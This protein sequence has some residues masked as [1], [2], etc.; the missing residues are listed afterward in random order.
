MAAQDAELLLK[1][2][3]DLSHFRGQLNRLG[4]D[5]AGQA[6]NLS[7][8]FNRSSVSS[9]LNLLQRQLG[10]KKF[11]VEV[12]TNLEAEIKNADRLVR[13]LQRVQSASSGAKGGL[14]LGVAGLGVKKG[15]GNPSVNEIRALFNAAI[16]G[17]LLDERTL[18]KT[19][20][21][22][23]V[24]LGQIGRDSI[25]G[26]LNGLSSGDSR[27]RAAAESLGD[28]LIAALK[29]ALGI[30]SPSKETGKLGKFAAEGFEKGFVSGMV[31]AERTMA[32]AIRS[33]VIGS[34]R[35]GLSN[36]P[37]LGG[38]LV[39]FERQ[40]AASVQLAV[41]RAMREGLS[42]SVGP[43][44]KGTLLGGT[45]G[46]ATGAAIGGAKALGGGIAAGVAKLTA[47]G[48]MGTAAN[49]ARY[50]I[51][52]SAYQEFVGK[53]YQEII[54]S[55][56]SSGS[57]GAI[58]GAL[59]VGGVAGGLGFARGATGSLAIQAITA[60]RNR[61]LAALLAVS[62][63]EMNNV[64]KVMVRDVTGALFTGIIRQLK[65]ASQGLPAINWPAIAPTKAAGIGPSSSGRFLPGGPEAAMLPGTAFGA[66]RRLVGDILSPSLKEALRG[67]ANA[68]VDTVRAELNAAIRQVNVRDLG[69]KV[70]AALA[71]SRIAGLLP[72]GVGR[73]PSTYATGRI[74]GETQAELFARR[75]REARMRSGL[76]GM[77]V[78]GGGAGR[79]PSPYS[80][81]YR[82]A[83]PLSAIVPYA[84][85]GAMV[86]TGGGGGGAGG[87][88][89]RPPGGGG[90]M[91]GGGG[92][93]GRALSNL[94][95]PGQGLIREL[96][97]EFG[98]AAKQVLLFGTAYKAL[99]FIQTFP[100][101]VGQAVGQL[102]SF[103]NTLKEISPSA[104][105]VAA[106]NKFILD[107]VDKYNVPLQSARDGFTKLYASM[108]P[109]GF[110]GNEIRDLFLGISQAAATFGM[111]AEKV[112]RV[113]YAFAQMA[114]KGQVMSEEL[115]GQ[116]GD[117][118]PGAMAIFA[119]A[120][121]F[122]GA[123]AITK[124][125][126][127]LE[128]GAYKG[129][130]MKVLLTNVGIVMRKEFGP[131]AEGAA[132]TFQGV[133]N[134]M[135]NSMKLLYEAFE[136]VAV[137]F[138]NS[139][140]MP[141][142]NGIK[143]ITDG[144]N[145]FFQ[146]VSAKTAGGQ[147][148]AAQ[149]ESLRPAFEG[150]LNNVKQLL[151]SLQLF[152]NA[153]L[154]VSKLFI[155]IAGNPVTGFLLKVYAN[156]LLLN[157]A[158]TLLGGRVLLGLIASINTAIAR[159]IA[160]NVSVA[161]LQRTSA[162]TSSALAGTQLQLALLT[163]NA[164][165]ATGPV[166]LLA[167]TLSRLAA[168]GAIVVT[169]SLIV[170]GLSE[171]IRAN[172]EIARLRGQRLAGGQAAIYGGSVPAQ[173]KETARKTL[174]SINKER[175][176][177]VPL[178]TRVLG[179]L[180]GLVGAP[181][182]AGQI[183]RSGVLAERELAA[184]AKLGLPTR[185]TVATGTEQVLQSMP[186]GAG[187]GAGKGG[188]K[189]AD[190]AKRLAEEIAKQAAAASNVLFTEQQRLS[191]LRAT[192]PIAKTFAEFASQELTIQREL[193][194]ALKEA[195]S[196]K[197]KQDIIETA[198]L[199]SMQ[200]S[201]T[202]EQEMQRV[203]EDALKPLQEL[204]TNQ[205]EQLRYET[206]VKDLM[207]QGMLPE[208]AKQVAE[209]RKLVRAQL[210]TLDLSIAQ[211]EAAIQER[212][213]RE[214]ITEAVQKQ[215]EALEDLRAARGQILG[216]G[217]QGEAGVPTETAKGPMDFIKEAAG[218]AREELDKLTNWG[219]QAVEGAKA[220]G[221]AF[222]Q[223]FK[224]I[225]S[226]SM[227]AQEALA[228]MMQSIADHFLDMAAQIIAQQ[229]TMMI[230][231]LILKAL[232]VMSGAAASVSATGPNPGGIPSTGNITAPSVN[233]FDLGS[234]ANV[235]AN[236]AVWKGGFQAF[237]NGGMVTGPTLGLIGEGKY[238]E[239]IVP[240]PN[241]R[242]IPVQLQGDSIREKMGDNYASSP[243]SPMLSMTFETTSINGVE[244]VS[245]DQLEAAM[246]ETR[247]LAAR[248]GAQKGAN[249]AIDKLQQSPNVRRRVGMR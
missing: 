20:E 19:R 197:E 127:A 198:R 13:A 97:Q 46:A 217:A 149:L 90:G 230:Y 84:P 21:Q 161:A 235:A 95:L 9:E 179:S 162:V 180:A 213:A 6:L 109:A 82:G 212:I 71:P 156:V 150:I 63:G 233:G 78:M 216:L 237:A 119:E 194:Q 4:S 157:T 141:L 166:A 168:I 49:L 185:A 32:N 202:L 11:R 240:L 232:G 189:A 10:N 174:A 190:E 47:G 177:G 25:E 81:A 59:A 77:D 186:A 51:D 209:V 167:S 199:K 76:R 24:A 34:I 80:Y 196:E 29:N 60:I 22:M 135:Q 175:K 65:S 193:N 113:N 83:R 128:D 68:F 226:G 139:V 248:E 245:R 244:Y 116:L 181:T 136:P 125:S 108:Q 130:A 54:N 224:D 215:Q 211:A 154:S 115:K 243:S 173:D 182:P 121:G 142:T 225:I 12:N 163:R 100:G 114:S 145:A 164:T 91:F 37:G 208:R 69:V 56:L 103:R 231:G 242:S 35:E 105:E 112:D 191:V 247:K 134:R 41:R 75:E 246:M 195:K 138:L 203:R 33:A 61:V 172:Q 48:V 187:E 219:Y 55:A 201:L 169:V 122:E 53:L 23:V 238:N 152:G 104:E 132:R 214:G 43:G 101:Q 106:S 204:L 62:T 30:A 206:D 234:V 144:F 221:S 70:Q 17:G 111:S 151:P 94:N 236:G 241:G 110:G 192:N 170:N 64:V 89:G 159:F 140:V 44:A 92:N 40:L 66:Q 120:A 16:K 93:F 58:I 42:A 7:V 249:L 137:G 67:A 28:S 5:L 14:P 3:L 88:G 124:F 205:R 107:I 188:K 148:F 72:A 117:V 129:K 147:A 200:N 184:R 183:E 133:I 87:G 131:G 228:N 79:T 18:G 160:L 38:A 158:F 118:L 57:Q 239:A 85:G 45:G 27:L 178:A 52:S 207:A 218:T 99:A 31:K 8:K 155:L 165:A 98:F 39:G 171:A 143:T 126:A 96:G 86:P 74:G 15:A 36:L 2:G 222:G 26:L 223:A 146:G 123:D 210:E 73:T 229:I 227:S 102:Q 176:R 153:L 1:V 220:I 50:S